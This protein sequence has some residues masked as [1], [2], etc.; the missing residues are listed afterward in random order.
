[1]NGLGGNDEINVYNQ[2]KSKLNGEFHQGCNN[3]G[4]R[5]NESGEIYFGKNRTVVFQ[6]GR[7]FEQAFGKITPQDDTG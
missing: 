2:K 5:D 3:N 1:M 4:K 6:E 7:G